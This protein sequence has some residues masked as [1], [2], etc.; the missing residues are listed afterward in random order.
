V[1]SAL[2]LPG[3]VSDYH[4]AMQ[5][6]AEFLYKRRRSEPGHLPFVEWL[7]SFDALLVEA[8]EADF[9]LTP[10]KSE[11]VNVLAFDFLVDINRREG[12]LN[13][14]LALARRFARFRAARDT[15]S[16]LE[17]RVAQMSAEYE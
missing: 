6:V 1:L 7:Y 11:Y 5:G 4:F 10:E 9:R 2:E 3:Q 8:H 16:E 13:D 17:A 14:A 15:V 12:R